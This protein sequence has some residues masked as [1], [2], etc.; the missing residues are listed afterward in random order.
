VLIVEV[1]GTV[2]IQLNLNKTLTT[3][4]ALSRVL[5]FCQAVIIN[6]WL[7]KGDILWLT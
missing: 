5:I 2:V 3:L 1:V 4:Q 7:T 6:E